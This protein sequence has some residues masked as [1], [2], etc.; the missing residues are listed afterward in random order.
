[1]LDSL[2]AS[3]LSCEI[4]VSC[5]HISLRLPR[6]LSGK[7]P[8]C[9][10]KKRRRCGFDP[11]VRKIPWRMKWQATLVF[12]PGKSHGQR[13]LAS[14][15]PCG[16][17]EWD[18]TEHAYTSVFCKS[19]SSL[20]KLAGSAVELSGCPCDGLSQEMRS[21]VLDLCIIIDLMVGSVTL[22]CS[23][24]VEAMHKLFLTLEWWMPQ[25]MNF[26]MLL[27]S[28]EHK[29]TPR[30]ICC[31][32]YEQA[33]GHWLCAVPSPDLE[34]FVSK[35]RGLYR[36]HCRAPVCSGFCMMVN[37]L[38]DVCPWAGGTAAPSQLGWY[39][40]LQA[41]KVEGIQR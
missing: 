37:A 20:R 23:L 6:W 36:R 7:E 15:S 21:E 26:L 29:Q 25:F 35:R 10:G 27:C 30:L 16:Q 4:L 38:G 13:S 1:M 33:A 14:Y 12:L 22:R 3:S 39:L 18:M 11:Q 17:K 41:R 8:A 5:S 19:Y 40:S 32:V 31:D 28:W 2:T 34:F 24:N 9:Q